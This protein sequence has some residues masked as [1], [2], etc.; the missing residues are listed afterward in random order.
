M[1]QEYSLQSFIRDMD[2]VTRA[3]NSPAA[4]VAAAKPLLA[5]LVQRPDCIEPQF[6][7]RGATE[8]GRYMLHRAP[9][10]NV[11]GGPGG[12][13]PRVSPHLTWR[14]DP[15]AGA[16]SPARH[17][18]GDVPLVRAPVHAGD[19]LRRLAARA[20]PTSRGGRR[21]DGPHSGG[22]PVG[23]ARQRVGSH[24]RQPRGAGRARRPSRHRQPVPLRRG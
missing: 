4:I 2:D 1:A 12:A 6:K 11:T 9:R 16:A 19:P 7:K 13:P 5:K 23:R 21:P 22:R 14:L 10:F 15:P 3:K 24:A 18:T 8:Y 20:A 17:P